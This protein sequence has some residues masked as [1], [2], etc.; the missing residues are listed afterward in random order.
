[1][2]I[3]AGYHFWSKKRDRRLGKRD[4][5]LGKREQGLADWEQPIY[6]QG[7]AASNHMHLVQLSLL[8]IPKGFG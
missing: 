4:R 6:N 2:K 7:P 1:M 8:Y 3:P 5:R